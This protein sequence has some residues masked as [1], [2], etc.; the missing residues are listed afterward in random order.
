MKGQDTTSYTISATLYLL[1][2]HKTIQDKVFAEIDEV[3][4]RSRDIP[5]TYQQFLDLKY[6]E[7]V[8]KESMRLYP[9]VEMI[10]REI[11]HDLKLGKNDECVCSQTK[12]ELFELKKIEYKLLRAVFR[13]TFEII[14]CSRFSS[15]SSIVRSLLCVLVH[16]GSAPDQ[17]N[18]TIVC[19]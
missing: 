1:S 5:I 13:A 4:G 7:M 2:R 16:S 19:S 9:A 17:T 10:G 15:I 6:M 18:T 12:L 14:L 8:V 11:N 3:I